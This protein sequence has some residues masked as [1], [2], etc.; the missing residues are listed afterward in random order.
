MLAEGWGRQDTEG[1]SSSSKDTGKMPSF[2]GQ[3]LLPADQREGWE[4][5]ALGGARVTGGE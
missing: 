3:Q 1:D 5:L 2:C 4:S